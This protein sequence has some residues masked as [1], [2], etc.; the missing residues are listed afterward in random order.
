MSNLDITFKGAERL[1]ELGNKSD[2]APTELRDL[3]ILFYLAQDGSQD[4]KVLFGKVKSEDP[5]LAEANFW[6]NIHG[7]RKR[8][9]VDMGKSPAHQFTPLERD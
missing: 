5:N 3:H 8:G 1:E 4:G 2:L 7:L 6:V 9:H